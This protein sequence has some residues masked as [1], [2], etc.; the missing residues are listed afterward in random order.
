MSLNWKE[1]N[2][3][4]EELDLGGSFVQQVVQPGFDSLAL[5]TY[6]NGRARTLLIHL[7]PGVCRLHET[8]QRVPRNDTP[9]RF[10]EFLRS[11]IRGCRIDRCEQLGQE[12]I[13]VMDLHRGHSHE[14]GG[15]G[16]VTDLH[17]GHGHEDGGCGGAAYRLYVR[18]WSN[19]ANVLLCDRDG[20]VLDCFF[21]RPKRG[22]VTGGHFAPALSAPSPKTA[23]LGVRDFRELIDRGHVTVEELGMLTFNQRVDRWYG[24]YAAALSRDALLEQAA[25]A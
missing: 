10:M 8:A 9:L 1:I 22:E 7:G 13:V 20:T 23:L 6:K 24:E 5:G 17:R 14:D 19:A 12:R 15:G 4:L 2:V 25:R 18:L 21:R 11:R 16:T 3:I